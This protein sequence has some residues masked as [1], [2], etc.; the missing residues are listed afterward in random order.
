M[1]PRKHERPKT[2]VHGSTRFV[3]WLVLCCKTKHLTSTRFRD[4][5]HE[6][7][8]AWPVKHE[9]P[10]SP[11]HGSTQFVYWLVLCC[12]TKQLT[13]TRSRDHVHEIDLV[14]P[15]KLS[16]RSNFGANLRFNIAFL[17][18]GAARNFRRADGQKVQSQSYVLHAPCR[19]DPTLAHALHDAFRPAV[20]TSA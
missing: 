10:K 16:L 20:A 17:I 2:P 9:R 12:Q 11:V 4:R 3:Y 1:W 14:W 6:I 19:V 13:S 8:L 15:A 7:D 5:V 18:P